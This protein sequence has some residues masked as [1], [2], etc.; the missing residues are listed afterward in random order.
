MMKDEL[1]VPD[2]AP[3]WWTEF[4]F[5]GACVTAGTAV[6]VFLSCVTGGACARSKPEKSVLLGWL[7]GGIRAGPSPLL[8][9]ASFRE[10]E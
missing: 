5:G 7:A 2:S 4:E 10:A 1:P 3:C 8:T 6:F 9:D